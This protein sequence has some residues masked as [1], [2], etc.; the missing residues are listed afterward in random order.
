MCFFFSKIYFFLFF[1]SSAQR[2]SFSQTQQ[3]QNFNV[4]FAAKKVQVG[5]LLKLRTWKMQREV[6]LTEWP[7]AVNRPPKTASPTIVKPSIPG[8]GSPPSAKTQ[9]PHNP[10]SV[11]PQIWYQS[12]DDVQSIQKNL[13][14]DTCNNNNN[15]IKHHQFGHQRW[16]NLPSWMLKDVGSNSSARVCSWGPGLNLSNSESCSWLLGSGSSLPSGSLKKRSVAAAV[17]WPPIDSCGTSAREFWCCLF[18][19]PTSHHPDGHFLKLDA[20]QYLYIQKEGK[21]NIVTSVLF[22]LV[23]HLPERGLLVLS[24]TNFK[25]LNL[26]IHHIQSLWYFQTIGNFS[27][28]CLFFFDNKL[29]ANGLTDTIDG[30]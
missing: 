12:H 28:F 3:L 18:C 8:K 26:K 16:C 7:H 22:F 20:I 1:F 27:Y 17:V 5:G 15:N 4:F 14:M 10:M 6:P 2:C 21:V 24:I 25:K 11:K 13:K 29:F 23:A 19:E 9:K 30:E